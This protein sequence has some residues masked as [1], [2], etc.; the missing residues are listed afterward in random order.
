MKKSAVLPILVFAA[1]IFATQPVCLAGDPDS[2]AFVRQQL[3]SLVAAIEKQY[4]T[5]PVEPAADA[6]PI[7][8][9]AE[10]SIELMDTAVNSEAYDLAL[11]YLQMAKWTG[12]IENKEAETYAALIRKLQAAPHDPANRLTFVEAFWNGRNRALEVE[13]FEARQFLIA[14]DTLPLTAE[15]RLQVYQQ[16][17]NRSIARCHYRFIEG[18][19]EIAL[20][21]AEKI[22]VSFPNNTSAVA[23]AYFRVAQGYSSQ[24][25]PK[26][27]REIMEQALKLRPPPANEAMLHLGLSEVCKVLEDE[28]AMLRHLKLAAKAPP[29]A[30]NRGIMD[31]YDTQQV[32]IVR[33]GKHYQE[34]KEFPTALKYFTSWRPSSW[35][36][37]CLMQMKQ[38]RAANIKACEAGIRINDEDE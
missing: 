26:V 17:I 33:L 8:R 21:Y 31:T 28:E 34:K 23:L 22:Q 3:Q 19:L 12:G 5:W 14:T 11:K 30:T 25:Q 20:K 7:R 29:I 16:I 13:S 35:C 9:R 32:A 15:Q 36:G 38:E 18:E 2:V 4:E 37:T 24:K 6:L 1:S 10:R 27:A